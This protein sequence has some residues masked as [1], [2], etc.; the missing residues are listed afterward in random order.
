MPVRKIQTATHFK[1]V[2]AAA[3][4]N[5]NATSSYLTPC[6]PADRGAQPMTWMKVDGDELL[7]PVVC[8][9]D[10]RGALRTVKPTVGHDDLK[11]HVDWMNDF[12][13]EG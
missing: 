3:R 7:E 5:P 13:Q 1:R 9:D 2:Q 4:D 6:N 11:K 12:G 10:M 8:M